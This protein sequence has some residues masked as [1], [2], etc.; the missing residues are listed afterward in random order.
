[1]PVVLPLPQRQSCL[2]ITSFQHP[3]KFP[4]GFVSIAYEMAYAF[5]CL[6]FLLSCSFSQFLFEP[7]DLVSIKY[8][9]KNKDA[10]YAD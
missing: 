3:N 4:D 8:G 5:I 2:Q 9:V 7:S 1:M 10:T 6:G